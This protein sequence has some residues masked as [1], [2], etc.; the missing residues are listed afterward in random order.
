MTDTL[1]QALLAVAE[2]QAAVIT[3]QRELDR[4]VVHAVENHE[5]TPDDLKATL[6]MILAAA[7]R[8]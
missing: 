8:A 4:R 7:R 3:A 2:A 1:W 5:A 6:D